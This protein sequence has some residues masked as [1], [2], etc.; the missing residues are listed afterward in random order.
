MTAKGWRAKLRSPETEARLSVV[1]VL[2]PVAFMT[3]LVVAWLPLLDWSVAWRPLVGCAVFC[4]AAS[5]GLAAAFVRWRP[6]FLK[7]LRESCRD[8]HWGVVGFFVGTFFLA[9]PV[10][11]PAFAETW[12]CQQ[13]DPV[14]VQ[15]S[16]TET[17]PESGTRRGVYVV[18]GESYGIVAAGDRWLTRQVAAPIPPTEDNEYYTRTYR[19]PWVGSEKVCGTADSSDGNTTAGLATGGILYTVP[20][21]I[22]V[23]ELWRRRRTDD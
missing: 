6:K 22:G 20:G 2:I 21:W 16:W 11:A 3:F 12:V 18:D 9:V 17:D 4:L 1:A 23:A 19:V 14:T 5:A 15:T 10:T 7:G 13:G 8:M